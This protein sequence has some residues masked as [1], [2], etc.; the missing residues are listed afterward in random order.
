MLKT[1]NIDIEF[2]RCDNIDKNINNEIDVLLKKHDIKWKFIVFY[3]SHQNE[4]IERVFRII[5]DKIR[6]CLHD[7]K[8]S[9]K[10]W[11]K[12]CHIIIYL[13][14]INSCSTL[15]NKTSYEIWINKK[16]DI[17]HFH[18]FDIICYAIKKK[19]KKLNKY[20]IKCRLLNYDEFNQYILWNIN[21]QCIHRA[22]HVFFDETMKTFIILKIQKNNE[23]DYDYATLN[24]NRFIINHSMITTTN[25]IDSKKRVD[26]FDISNQKQISKLI[27][28]AKNEIFEIEF[29]SKSHDEII[30]DSTKMSIEIIKI[31]SKSILSFSS[32]RNSRNKNLFDD[33]FARMNNSWNKKFE[34]VDKQNIDFIRLMKNKNNFKFIAKIQKFAIRIKKI[35]FIAYQIFQTFDDVMIHIDKIF[36]LNLWKKKLIIIKKNKFDDWY[37]FHQN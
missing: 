18:S 19:V 36:F 13:K 29:D 25:F 1:K 21:K 33:F 37:Y 27:E 12:I 16:F 8:L 7:V 6:I 3:N 2:I 9:K 30:F 4:M 32:K 28:N 20:V 14:N 5:F 15:I 17:K 31:S 11:K 26:V 22:T 35:K 34:N 24:F 10:F 23:N